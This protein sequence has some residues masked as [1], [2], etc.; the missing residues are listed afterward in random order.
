MRL[1]AGLSR[2][3]SKFTPVVVGQLQFCG[4]LCSCL[5]ALVT[6][7]PVTEDQGRILKRFCFFEI[8]SAIAQAGRNFLASPR[9]PLNF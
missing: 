5:S 8:M 1:L 7:Q 3:A 9:M 4:I 2:S 6:Q